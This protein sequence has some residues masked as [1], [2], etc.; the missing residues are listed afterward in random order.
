MT[1]HT[2]Y[3]KLIYLFKCRYYLKYKDCAKGWKITHLEAYPSHNLSAWTCFPQL[4]LKTTVWQTVLAILELESQSQA[5]PLAHYPLILAHMVGFRL[6][7][8]VSCSILFGFY[9]MSIYFSILSILVTQ[10]IVLS[11]AVIGLITWFCN[12][13]FH[14]MA[15]I[16]VIAHNI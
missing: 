13:Y 7:Q 14:T 6:V 12:S 16:Y 11:N 3:I 9:M 2:L 8:E 15:C 1:S 5:D 4:T 10:N